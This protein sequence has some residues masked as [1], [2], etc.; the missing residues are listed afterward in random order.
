MAIDQDTSHREKFLE[1]I[2]EFKIISPTFPTN[3]PRKTYILN[4]GFSTSTQFSLTT[5]KKAKGHWSQGYEFLEL[6]PC[7]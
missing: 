5:W 2:G 3:I 6:L 7:T 1:L 4:I